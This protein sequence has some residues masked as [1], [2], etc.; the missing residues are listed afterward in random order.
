MGDIFT[1]VQS[2][3]FWLCVFWALLALLSWRWRLF[4]HL[5]RAYNRSL[6]LIFHL[7]VWI[8]QIPF[9]NRMREAPR[10]SAQR[11]DSNIWG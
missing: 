3:F 11:N 4:G 2:L 6:A 5:F 8:M 9:K 7:A 1:G 10:C